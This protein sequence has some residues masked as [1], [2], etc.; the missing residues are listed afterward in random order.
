VAEEH[1]ALTVSLASLRELY[2][3]LGLTPTDEEI[4][5]LLPGVQRMFEND[6]LLSERFT[7]EVEPVTAP[8]PRPA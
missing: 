5:T 8:H 2:T 1:P 3:R 6:R 4:T 7:S